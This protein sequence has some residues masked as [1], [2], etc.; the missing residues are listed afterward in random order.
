MI[1]A[2]LKF[3]IGISL[4]SKIGPVTAKKLIAYTGGVEAVFRE[5][6]SN[7]KKIPGVG[8][9]LASYIA[10]QNVM[11][12]AEKEVVFIDKYQYKLIFIWTKI[13]P[14]D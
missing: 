2:Q 4:I 7:L 12:R 11:E 6:I 13:T 8:E 14:N 9:Q 5:K 3:K 10:N 1:D